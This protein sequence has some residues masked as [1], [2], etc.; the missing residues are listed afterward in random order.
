[1]PRAKKITR[2]KAEP[3]IDLDNL[4]GHYI[5][6]L[7]QIAVAIFLDESREFEVTPVQYG[8]LQ[9]ISNSPG[10]DQRTLA[11]RIGFD[12]STI[13]GVIDRLDARGLVLRSASETDRR[14][15]LL[16]LTPAGRTLTQAV[17]PTMLRAQERIL[18][19]LPKAERELFM[20]M[21]RRLVEAN[22]DMSRAPGDVR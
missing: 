15:R 17:V 14:V 7:Q 12:T 18:A 5:R 2:S 16:T 6:R 4:P 21:L 9:A 11:S 13:G 1:M 20:T 8:A 19:P 3:E 22:N 10:I